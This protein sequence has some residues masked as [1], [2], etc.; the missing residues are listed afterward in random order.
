MA[1]L[2]RIYV[3]IKAVSLTSDPQLLR[4][5]LPP[6]NAPGGLLN[7]RAFKSAAFTMYCI[8]AFVVFLGLYTR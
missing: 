2:V 4:R 7:L 8:S 6:T 1:N 3:D 5:R